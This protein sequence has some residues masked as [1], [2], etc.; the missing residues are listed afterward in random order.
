MTS[1]LKIHKLTK[2]GELKDWLADC[3]KEGVDTVALDL[4]T[5]GLTRTD[6]IISGAVT[7]PGNN[8]AF[9]GPEMLHELL[10]APRGCEFVFHNAPFDLKMLSWSGVRLQ[11]KFSY[12]DTLI[13]SHLLDESGEHGL[14]ALVKR[15]FN[16][17]YKAHFWSKYKKAEDAPEAELAAYNSS[18][19]S[20]TLQLY[21]HL[22]ELLNKDGVPKTLVDHVH[23]LQRS[24]LE[25]EI[26]GIAVD[27]DYLMQKGVELRSKIEDLLP[28]M[29]ESVKD[30]VE[31][32]EFEEWSKELGKRKTAVGR[33]R[34]GRPTF[35]FDSS[36]QLQS[37]LYGG[38]RL[39]EQR[40]EKTKKVSVDYD[41]L[42]RIKHLHPVVGMLQEY[43]EA[44]KIYGTYIEGT[45][46]RM[47]E[48]RIYPSFNVAGTATGRISHSNPNMGNMPREGGIRGIF[49]PDPGHV[50]ISAD[51]SQLEVCLSAHFTRDANLLRIINEGVSQHDITAASLGI[52]RSNA[53]NV[54]FAC[55]YGAGAF[56]LAKMLGVSNAEG[57]KALAKYW[58]TYSGQKRV[59]DECAAKV[60]RG[61][62]IIN[63][64]G[65]RRRFETRKRPSWDS[66][67]RQAWNALVQGTGSDCTSRAFY[68]AD[69]RL[70]KVGAGRAL[71][72][73]H[74]EILCQ[75]KKE[76]WEE[77]QK[78]LLE[79]MTNVGKELGLTVE[80]KAQ[81]SGSCERWLD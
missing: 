59:M 74:D 75:V 44:Q 31:L 53:K 57:E 28:K 81:G 39:P 43:R 76:Y 80:L 65:R 56:K 64:F 71:F 50:F 77:G 67:Y 32:I 10:Q 68:L 41:S 5:T 11:D 36:K 40:N 30:E 45:L 29:R 25:T 21:Y 54:N 2:P 13:L 60:D 48:G 61:E 15:Y 6:K 22:Q 63:P 20:Y 23:N 19:V 62:P 38:L 49:Q 27:R 55:Q 1:V 37:L 46:E 16:D 73:I 79:T 34:V 7:G 35:S 72:T 66:A 4:E 26:A 78:I 52:S 9:F 24:L 70:R 14:G 69:A 3:A 42:E 51:F 58:E 12:H 8:V 33:S 47:V 17:D 18:D